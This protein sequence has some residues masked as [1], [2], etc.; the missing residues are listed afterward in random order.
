MNR[1]I[2][3]DELLA[4]LQQLDPRTFELALTRCALRQAEAQLEALNPQPQEGTT[5]D[6]H[7]TEEAAAG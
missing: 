3:P 2:P 7:H 1:Q 6:D 5:T 4:E